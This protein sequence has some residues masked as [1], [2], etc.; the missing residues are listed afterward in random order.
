MDM[1][2]YKENKYIK[3]Y[4]HFFLTNMAIEYCRI[5]LIVLPDIVL[6][7]VAGGG[8]IWRMSPDGR[9]KR[10][11]GSQESWGGSVSVQV[12]QCCL[13]NNEAHT[14]SSGGL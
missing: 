5:L 10:M 3:M 4:V 13:M 11:W 9:E 2:L 1:R 14:V 8:E 12:L 6:A 7:M